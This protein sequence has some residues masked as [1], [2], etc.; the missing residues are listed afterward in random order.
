MTF[1]DLKF[2]RQDHTGGIICQV[3]FPNGYG[4]SVIRSR[5]SY[6]GP[7]GLYELAV[8]LGREGKCILT[9]DTPVTSDV[10]GHL[11]E[12]GVTQK[13]QAIEALPPFGSESKTEG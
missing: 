12:D 4:A 3:F 13:L 7:E 1:N 8:L 11:S 10:I 2:E 5:M 6:G 9:Y